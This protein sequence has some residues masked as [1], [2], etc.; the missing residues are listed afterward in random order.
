MTDDRQLQKTTEVETRTRSYDDQ[1]EITK[2]VI[3]VTSTFVYSDDDWP[4]MYL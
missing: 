1:G 3:V 2:E 4:G